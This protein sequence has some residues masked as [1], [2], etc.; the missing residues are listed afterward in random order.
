MFIINFDQEK[1]KIEK[2]NF[3]GFCLFVFVVLFFFSPCFGFR[4]FQRGVVLLFVVFFF[5]NLIWI[6]SGKFS[7]QIIKFA[8]SHYQ[9]P[10]TRGLSNPSTEILTKQEEFSVCLSALITNLT[11]SRDLDRICSLPLSS[12][13]S[14]APRPVLTLEL[15]A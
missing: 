10:P 7:A 8:N 11:E 4:G 12:I 9:Q 5:P 14:A 2:G 15:T 1:K 13:C 3:S 6:L